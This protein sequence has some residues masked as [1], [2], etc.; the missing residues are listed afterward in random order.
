MEDPNDP[1]FTNIR[2]LKQIK[3]RGTAGPLQPLVAGACLCCS[4]RLASITIFS[5]ALNSTTDVQ[6]PCS[7]VTLC[8]GHLVPAYDPSPR[9]VVQ[10]MQPGLSGLACQQFPGKFLQV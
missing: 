6:A 8:M 2:Y 1:G 3:L 9:D 5:S 4:R 7:N 10:E